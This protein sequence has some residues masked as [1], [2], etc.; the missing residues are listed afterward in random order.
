[1]HSRGAVAHADLMALRATAG[2]GVGKFDRIL[3]RRP[4]IDGAARC[5]AR[6]ER[7][8]SP[9]VEEGS[10]VQAIGRSTPSGAGEPAL[11]SLEAQRARYTKQLSECVNCDLAKTAQGKADIEAIAARIGQIDTRIAKVWEAPARGEPAHDGNGNA[12]AVAVAAFSAVSA[13][14]GSRIDVLA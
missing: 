9:I 2:V 10:M 1:M 5:A 13:T 12:T 14:V 3:T 7:I 11:A 6:P 8:R 4:D